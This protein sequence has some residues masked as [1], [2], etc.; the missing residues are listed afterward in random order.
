MSR[1]GDRLAERPVRFSPQ[2]SQCCPVFIKFA[3]AQHQDRDDLLKLLDCAQSGSFDK[4]RKA[5]E[6]LPRYIQIVPE[7]QDDVVNAVYD[8]CEDPS[9]E[10]SVVPPNFHVC[11]DQRL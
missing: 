10:A 1:Q 3:F 11:V 6:D 7:M 4:K 9:A 5:A 2:L 8:L